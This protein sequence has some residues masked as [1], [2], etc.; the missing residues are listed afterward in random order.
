MRTQGQAKPPTTATAE[1]P[2]RS[3]VELIADLEGVDLVELSPPLYSVIDPEALDSLFHS[4]GD[5][6]TGHVDFEYHGYQ[7][8]VRS[9]GEV[10]IASR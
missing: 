10:E 5:D 3:I 2:S 7:V 1:K 6:V 4:S 9:D 8:R